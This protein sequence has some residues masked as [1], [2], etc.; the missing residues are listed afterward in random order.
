MKK[1]LAVAGLLAA[2][3]IALSACASPGTGVVGIWGDP[4]AQGLPSLEFTAEADASSG[5][6]SGTDGCNR[7]GGEY[8][9]NGSTVDLG[10]MRSTLMFCEGVDTWLSQAR[11]ANLAGD[12]LTFLDEGGQELGSLERQGGY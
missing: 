3:L 11:T 12:L 4:E 1:T 8:S 2:A 10:M 6:Y 9:V 7:L 5:E